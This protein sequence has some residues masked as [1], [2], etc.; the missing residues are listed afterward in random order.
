MGP[1][2]TYKAKEGRELRHD[3][4]LVTILRIEAGLLT[5]LFLARSPNAPRM[6]ITVLFFS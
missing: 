4:S 2:P 6:M 1:R 3:K 5:V